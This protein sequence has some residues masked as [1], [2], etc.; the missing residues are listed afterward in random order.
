MGKKQT[1]DVWE[2]ELEIRKCF[3]KSYEFKNLPSKG[4]LKISCYAV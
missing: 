3:E 1:H 2:H 4:F